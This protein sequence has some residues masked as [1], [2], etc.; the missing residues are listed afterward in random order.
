MP[1]V[2]VIVTG[3]GDWGRVGE[4]HPAWGGDRLGREELPEHGPPTEENS[5]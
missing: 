5:G 1:S 4:V 3:D 2:F